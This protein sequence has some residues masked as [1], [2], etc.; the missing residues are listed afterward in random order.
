M[1]NISKETIKC[2]G[3]ARI[4]IGI[5]ALLAS[6]WKQF[7]ASYFF[8]RVTGWT[9]S[10]KVCIQSSDLML[11]HGDVHPCTFTSNPWKH[12]GIPHSHV[13]WNYS[14]GSTPLSY[15]NNYGVLFKHVSG[16]R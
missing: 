13:H 1:A 11:K 16:C 15:P 8:C 5:M 10:L 12:P 14:G 2:G 9:N 6:D 3:H 4:C 7:C